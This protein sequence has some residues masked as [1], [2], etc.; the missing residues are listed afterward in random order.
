MADA[1]LPRAPFVGDLVRHA[2]FG[3]SPLSD[4]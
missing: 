3:L 1:L 4:A 2:G